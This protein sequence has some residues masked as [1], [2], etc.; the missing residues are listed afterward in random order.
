MGGRAAFKI[1]EVTV[2]T[3]PKLFYRIFI[4]KCVDF[5]QKDLQK[6]NLSQDIWVLGCREIITKI[7]MAIAK[8]SKLKLIFFIFLDYFCILK[9]KGVFFYFSMF[10]HVNVGERKKKCRNSVVLKALYC[11]LFLIINIFYFR[12]FS[13]AVEIIK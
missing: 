12:T 6:K 2:N 10:K 7:K 9:L 13:L 1:K 4:L 3:T 11:P 8:A 5:F